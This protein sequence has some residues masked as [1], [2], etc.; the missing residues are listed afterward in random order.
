MPPNERDETQP[1]VKPPITADTIKHVPPA[2]NLAETQDSDPRPIVSH[3]HRSLQPGQTISHYKLLGIVGEGAFGVV[4]KARDTQLD[5]SVAIK[6]PKHNYVTEREQSWFFREARAAAKLKH[7]SIVAVYDVGQDVNVRYIVSEFIEGQSLTDLLKNK[8]LLP[9]PAAELCKQIADAVAHAHENGITH[10]D[11]KPSNIIMDAESK[12]HLLDFG[13]AKLEVLDQSLTADDLVLGTPGYMSPEQA[14]GASRDADARSDVYSLG[15][16][17]FQLLTGEL[18]FRGTFH[19]VV[20]QH[21]EIPAPSPR[22]LDGKIPLDLESIVLRCLEKAPQH[23]FDNA[24]ELANELNRYLSGQP[25]SFRPQGAIT[26]FARWFVNNPDVA[27][28]T[29]GIICVL[30]GV[31]FVLWTLT[32]VASIL[33]GYYGQED[34][35]AAL[36]TLFVSLLLIGFPLIG[37]GFA[38]LKKLSLAVP[39]SL[40]LSVT[41]IAQATMGMFGIIGREDLHGSVHVRFPLFSLLILISSSWFLLAL[42][43]LI[44]QG[45]H[46]RQS[47]KSITTPGD[48]HHP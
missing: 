24:K 13:L 12:P 30:F 28:E 17:L 37:L 3:A 4:W 22:G 46:R 45:L 35:T 47:N 27:R 36:V 6:I 2:L 39:L 40:G 44:S 8:P 41:G 11:L 34:P 19:A 26:R 9:R 32:G 7:A 31:I 29:L 43:V 42:A 1:P 15:I 5:R 23:R 14:R 33:I 18:P 20:R 21:I 16:L 10:R 25:L 38:I 48:V